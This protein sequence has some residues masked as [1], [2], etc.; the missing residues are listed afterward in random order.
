MAFVALKALKRALKGQELASDTLEI[1]L[2]NA[3]HWNP[4]WKVDDMLHFWLLAFYLHKKTTIWLQILEFLGLT[5]VPDMF[6]F[7][8]R[9]DFSAR[10]ALWCVS[11]LLWLVE[12]RHLTDESSVIGRKLPPY[13]QELCDWLNIATFLQKQRQSHIYWNEIEMLLKSWQSISKKKVV[14]L[15]K[16]KANSQKCDISSTFQQGFQW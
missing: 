7:T 6:L 13:W 1:L 15:W 10:H 16:Y 9:T 3:Y 14:F 12:N 4:G 5:S 11:S 8:S 2:A